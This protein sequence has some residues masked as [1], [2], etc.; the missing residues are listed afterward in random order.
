MGK[1]LQA[2]VPKQVFSKIAHILILQLKRWAYR[3]H[4]NKSRKWIKDKNFI[5]T[6]S[7]DWRFGFNYEE[8]NKKRNFVV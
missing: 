1:L 5:K 7:R 4:T 2:L 8:C 6:G 3:R